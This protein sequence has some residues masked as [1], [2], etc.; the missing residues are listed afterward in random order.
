[1]IVTLDINYYK[2]QT[3]LMTTKNILAVLVFTMIL[4]CGNVDQSTIR[5]LSSKGET[6]NSPLQLT[7]H[8]TYPQ[9]PSTLIKKEKGNV[10]KATVK[11]NS[12]DET[13][14]YTR[15]DIVSPAPQYDIRPTVHYINASTGGQF[16]YMETGSTVT[17]PPDALVDKDGNEVNGMVQIEYREF[18]TPKDI[19]FSGIPMDFEVNGETQYFESAGMLEI[20]AYHEGE[21]LY[22]KDG[23]EIGFS[24]STDN[25]NEEVMLY[26]LNPK[27][28]K[29][30]E[31]SK[32]EV[33]N[34]V[35][36]PRKVWGPVYKTVKEKVAKRKTIQFEI[37]NFQIGKDPDTQERQKFITFRMGIF[38]DLYRSK[39]KKSTRAERAA[40]RTF[41]RISF[42]VM[43]YNRKAFKKLLAD[44]N[45]SSNQRYLYQLA[46]STD[47]FLT[48]PEFPDKFTITFKNNQSE[49]SLKARIIYDR[50]LSP[51]MKKK[52]FDQLVSFN[53]NEFG[54]R[55]YDKY[56]YNSVIDHYDSLVVSDFVNQNL[57]QREF[58]SRSFGILNCDQPQKLPTGMVADAAFYI[59]DKKIKPGTVT[60]VDFKK[61]CLFTYYSDAFEKF[62]FNP[63]SKNFIFTMLQ[64][65][66]VAFIMPDEFQ[67]IQ[68]NGKMKVPMH[69]V[70][71]EELE[72]VMEELFPSKSQ[73]DFE[74]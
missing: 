45:G 34:K 73:K 15:G 13:H 57:V 21:K 5:Q 38:H 12:I 29:W 1:M 47:I 35:V 28:R 48:D 42:E 30:K 68:T 3:G 51:K 56:D 4:S 2:L 7:S 66:N 20:N 52:Y 16:S 25:T 74:I 36:A 8:Q 33:V 53:I 49:V 39:L 72:K 71:V 67:A 40:A 26:E 69:L 41:N 54:G 58:T 24:M 46:S 50:P 60:L 10:K 37:E 31:L 32:P 62:K 55:Y 9:E 23:K 18:H 17:I 19:F 14:L 27:T 64:D 61:N 63:D 22:L 44:F 65:G 43:G 6:A 59:Q 70:N 11:E